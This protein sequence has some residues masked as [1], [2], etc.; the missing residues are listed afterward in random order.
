MDKLSQTLKH[1]VKIMKSRVT[2]YAVYGAVIAFVALILATLLS[3]YFQF[4]E[5]TL[6]GIMESQKTNVT[7]WF[8][9]AMPFIFAFWGQY[10]SSIMA[11]EAGTMIIDQTA[12]LRD[13]TVALEYKAAHDA[14]HDA[15]TDLPNRVLLLDRVEQA[16]Q[17]AVLQKNLLG[18]LILDIDNFKEINDTLGQYSGDRLL[19]QVVSRLTGVVKK[20]DTLA[21]L[22]GGEFAILIQGVVERDNAINIVKKIQKTFTTPFLIEGLRL[23]VQARIGIAIFPEHGKNGD[24]II[25]RAN[26]ALYAAKETSKKY[27]IYSSQLDKNNPH[28]LTMMGELR[29]GIENNELILYYQPKINM[30]TRSVKGVEALVRWQHPEHGFMAPEEFIPMAERTGL[31]KLLS[32]WVLNNALGQAEK[33]YRQNLKMSI[34]INLS[35]TA[36]L[37]TDLPDMIIGML[38]RYDI[39]A[40][41]VILEITEGS[42]IKDPTLAME[43]L[44]RLTSRGIKISID[45]FGTGYS[46]F[47]YLKELPVSEVKIDKSFIRDMVINDNDAVIVKSIIDLGHNLS[48]NVVAEGVQDKETVVK[49]KELGC[50]ELQGNFFSKP[51]SSGDFYKLRLEK[52]KQNTAKKY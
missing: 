48:L 12:D 30:L 33:W 52:K 19:K 41:L 40:N 13:V 16:I 8:L 9:D 35:P 17:S 25:Q 43:I 6:E 10:T 32:I 36:F 27:T 28:R 39:P 42:M 37:D 11:Y 1:N 15:V 21:R 29:Q 34:S 49:L 45:D 20:S 22:D 31:I 38:S 47:A 5:I 7:L 24:T 26:L 2:K 51:L 4:G 23:E 50:D 46:S 18:L 14:T 44:N 3:S